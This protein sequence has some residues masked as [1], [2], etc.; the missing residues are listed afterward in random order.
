MLWEWGVKEAFEEEVIAKYMSTHKHAKK[1]VC[2]LKYEI[3][4][5]ILE[6]EGLR[7]MV[8]P[9][10]LEQLKTYYSEGVYGEKAKLTYNP[11]YATENV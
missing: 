7:Q 5:F 11:E 9:P 4:K 2:E 10:R 1:E 3:I 6:N 8:Q